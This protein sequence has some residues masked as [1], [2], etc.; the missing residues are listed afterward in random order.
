MQHNH[1]SQCTVEGNGE[2]FTEQAD[3]CHQELGVH[4][5][6]LWQ[7]RGTDLRRHQEPQ[8]QYH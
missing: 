6:P 1:N 3:Q 4:C 5:P 2:S 8:H 7:E